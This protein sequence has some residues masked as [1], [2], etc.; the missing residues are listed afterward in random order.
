M[1]IYLKHLITQ[2]NLNVK[3]QISKHKYTALFFLKIP[4]SEHIKEHFY[5]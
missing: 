2:K 5:N 3:F 4:N 1:Y